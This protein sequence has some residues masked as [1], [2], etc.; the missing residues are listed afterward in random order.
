MENEM[1][2][3]THEPKTN[4]EVIAP[5]EVG[6]DTEALMAEIERLKGEVGK[7]T[8]WQSRSRRELD[9][10]CTLYP[11]VPLVGLPD[12]V[13]SDVDAGVPLA[14]AYALY[15]KKEALRSASEKKSA[16]RSWRGMNQAAG[17]DHFSP[18]DVKAMSQK[19]VHKN[20]KKIMESMK[21]WK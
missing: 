11:S 9:E 1:I 17:D 20:Y 18:A 8:E 15:E 21:H 19:E 10:F 7:L 4:Q 14:A 16:E 2:Q 13:K 5:T 3:E 12:E 6:N